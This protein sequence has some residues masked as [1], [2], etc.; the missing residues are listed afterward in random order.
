M[1]TRYQKYSHSPKGIARAYKYKQSPKG[2][3]NERRDNARPKT[4]ERKAR[5][6]RNRP[7][8]SKN[9][10]QARKDHEG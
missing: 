2:K 9:H 4:L 10:V 8:R 7:T 3:E 6:E 5:Y 1:M